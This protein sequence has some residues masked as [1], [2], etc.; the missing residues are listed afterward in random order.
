MVDLIRSSEFG[1]WLVTEISRI[2]LQSKSSDVDLA[3]P[4]GLR[5]ESLKVTKGVLLD[6]LTVQQAMLNAASEARAHRASPSP[7]GHRQLG[8]G[9]SEANGA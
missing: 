8:M 5:L 3:G 4:A 9:G 1:D 6:F 2:R 7:R